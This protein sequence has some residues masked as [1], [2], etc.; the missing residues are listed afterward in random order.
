EGGLRSGESFDL[1]P[2]QFRHN[3][4]GCSNVGR[5]ANWPILLG[6]VVFFCCVLTFP[7]RAQQQQEPEDPED[8]KQ[9]GL[10]LDQG[11]SADLSADKSL[12]LEF[13]ER[14]DEG[15]SNLYEYF[16]L[17]WCRFSSAALVHIDTDL[18]LPASPWQSRNCL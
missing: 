8:E 7:A 1:L 9:I 11:I 2:Q 18:S 10:W 14:F 4:A 15:A 6:M 17:A 16:V 12:K 5:A 13:H 3:S